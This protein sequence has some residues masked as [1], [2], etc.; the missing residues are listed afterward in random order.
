MNNPN[1]ILILI[2]SA[3][4]NGNTAQ[5]ADRLQSAL[6]ARCPNSTIDLINLQD[7]LIGAFD[8]ECT[9]ASDQLMSVVDHMLAAST[10]VFA[11]PVYWYAMATIMKNFFD[12]LTDLVMVPA[13][14]PKGRSLAGRNTFLLSNGAYPD[15]PL[16]F[17]EPFRLTSEYLSMR[18]VAGRYLRFDGDTLP[19]AETAQLDTLSEAIARALPA[20]SVLA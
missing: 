16:G 18:F 1:T 17:E 13:N 3:R 15:L 10:I 14:R 9:N 8:Y 4:R 7:L 20:P 5:T 12:R 6:A 2:G 19:Q 11:T